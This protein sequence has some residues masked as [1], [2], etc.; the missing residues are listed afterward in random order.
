[1][2]GVKG[3]RFILFFKY[4][5]TPLVYKK[6]VC[7]WSLA[8]QQSV[9]QQHHS[10]KHFSEFYP[11]DGGESQLASKLCHSHRMYYS[12]I[13]QKNVTEKTQPHKQ[14]VEQ[15][16]EKK[17]K[18]MKDNCRMTKQAYIQIQLK[19]FFRMVKRL[20][21][22]YTNHNQTLFTLTFR[23]LSETFVRRSCSILLPV[24]ATEVRK[25]RDVARTGRFFWQRSLTEIET[26]R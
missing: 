25:W 13:D 17:H 16:H 6:N 4:N 14:S 2:F 21:K 3:R 1:M 23:P 22:H 20:Y 19:T 26:S 11:Q 7:I 24:L 10:G 18:N 5:S 9:F 8:C 12:W 15:K